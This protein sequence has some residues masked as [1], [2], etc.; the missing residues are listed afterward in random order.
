MLLDVQYTRFMAAPTVMSVEMNYFDWNISSPA[1]TLCPHYKTDIMKLVNFVNETY[2]ATEFQ[3]FAYFWAI[4]TS[5]L[6]NLEH[7]D[8][9]VPE[10]IKLSVDPKDYATIA[11][12]MFKKF[13]NNVFTT[14]NKWLL[15][16]EPAMTEMG[17]CYVINSNVA[18]YDVPRKTNA[19]VPEYVKKNI[20]LSL[21]DIDFFTV[22]TN[23]KDIYKVFIHSPDDISMTTTSSFL[24]DVEGAMSFG[25]SVQTTRISD[26]LRYTSLQLRKCRFTNEPISKRYPIYSHS[27]CIME[28]RIKMIQ[29]LCG[30][31]PHFYRTLDN[32]RICYINELQCVLYHRK[33][34]VKLST[35]KET[36]KKFNHH[37]D[38]PITS[39]D[40]GCLN[41][42]ELDLYYRDH[43][44]FK[45]QSGIRIM[46]I[47][48]TSFPKVRFVRDIIF[49]FYDIILRIGGVVNLCIGSSIISLVEIL[50]L[51]FNRPKNDISHFSSRDSHHSDLEMQFPHAIMA[52]VKGDEK[53]TMLFD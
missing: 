11:A 4:T 19:P 17:M 16:I 47:K 1:I 40:C 43:E 3:S 18:V 28:C 9:S 21:Y 52:N 22:F 53:Q 14:N 20:D 39:R 41:T 45:Q 49:N 32:E 27:H 6:D 23:Y 5:A 25:L 36:L 34:I 30:C 38:L 33:E 37:K 24:F 10:D 46:K 42:C 51:I 15:S 8:L 48:I 31:V 12:S 44:N 35:L 50:L 13:E 29:R 26:E 2:K 7:M